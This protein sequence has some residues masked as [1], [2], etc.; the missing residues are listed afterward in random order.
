MNITKRVDNLVKTLNEN[1]STYIRLKKVKPNIDTN[2][3]IVEEERIQ[4][5]KESIS[6]NRFRSQFYPPP[7]PCPLPVKMKIKRKFRKIILPSIT[8]Q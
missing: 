7:V 2:N 3:F 4:K 5:L 6:Q 1:Q 8:E